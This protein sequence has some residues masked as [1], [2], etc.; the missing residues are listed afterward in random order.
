MV[1]F[2][3]TLLVARRCTYVLDQGCIHSEINVVGRLVLYKYLSIIK[4][5]TEPT[6]IYDVDRQK[7]GV[8]VGSTFSPPVQ[9]QVKAKKKWKPFFCLEMLLL[10]I[11]RQVTLL[12]LQKYII[13]FIPISY[14]YHVGSAVVLKPKGC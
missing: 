13:Y 12:F 14:Y 6:H 8:D 11:Y 7:V 9:C 10:K 2:S 3:Q 4:T 1:Y 5:T